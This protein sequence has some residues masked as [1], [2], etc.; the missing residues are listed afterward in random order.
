MAATPA[1]EPGGIPTIALRCL[2][3]APMRLRGA[4]TA[5]AYEFTA[6]QPVQ[7]VAAPDALGL[8][9]S[10]LFRRA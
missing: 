7:P 5:R 10:R 9:A 2:A 1:P 6:D 4:V 3:G 8:L